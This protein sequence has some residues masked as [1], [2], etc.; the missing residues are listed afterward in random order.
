MSTLTAGALCNDVSPLYG[1][2][3]IKQ[4]LYLP[5]KLPHL[6]YTVFLVLHIIKTPFFLQT[7]V[8]ISIPILPIF[9]NYLTSSKYNLISPLTTL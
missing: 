6:I 2:E 4:T 8:E 7:H 1:P 5:S 9:H 3:N